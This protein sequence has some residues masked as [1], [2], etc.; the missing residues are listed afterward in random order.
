MIN[1]YLLYS[2]GGSSGAA[3]AA[4]KVEKAAAAFGVDSSEAWVNDKKPQG[5]NPDTVKNLTHDKR[6]EM[7]M[8]QMDI[9][10]ETAERYASAIEA[11]GEH[12]AAMQAAL[13]DT[14]SP[15]HKQ[16]LDLESYI[17]ETSRWAG[18][19]TYRSLDANAETFSKR[20]NIG[21][22]ISFKGASTWYSNK[23]NVKGEVRLV[24]ETQ[25]KGTGI[26]HLSVHSGDKEVLA[27]DSARYKIKKKYWEGRVLYVQVEEI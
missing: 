25:S 21:E 14:S 4:G 6:V 15:Y 16:A 18:G 19:D 12:T 23:E 13:K 11:Y 26:N 2:S 22:T 9:S 20:D 24:S 17:K 8:D 5:Q 7:L 3:G 10:K 1:R 27:S